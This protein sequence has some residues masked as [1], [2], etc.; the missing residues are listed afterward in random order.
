MS[1]QCSPGCTPV[2]VTP[3]GGVWMKFLQFLAPFC[4]CASEPGAVLQA[5]AVLCLLLGLT[6]QEEALPLRRPQC[7]GL[8]L[9]GLE[10][11]P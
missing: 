6:L 2:P 8:C 9:P 11:K 3:W 4:P 10:K 5:E 7:W 1:L